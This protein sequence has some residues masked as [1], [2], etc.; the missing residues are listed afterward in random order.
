MEAENNTLLND[1]ILLGFLEVR[2]FC[3]IFI[4]AIY[5]MIIFGNFSV[6]GIIQVDNH[7]QTPMYFFLSCLSLLDVCYSTVTLPAMLVN[8][9]T[10]NRRISFHRCFTQLYFFVCFGGSECLLLAA[11]AYDRYVA[12][13]NPLRYNAVMNRKFCSG[14]VAGCCACG[15]LNAVFHTLMILKLTFCGNHHINH[16]FCDVLPILEAACS[17][18]QGSQVLL[19]VVTVFLGM[20]PFLLVMNSYIHIISTILKIRSSEGRQKVFS[21]CSS[22]LI[23][24]TIFYTTGMFS[25]NGPS[26]G[27]YFIIVRVSS[28]LY[29][30]LP[31]LLNPI[32]YCLR[33]KDVKKALKKARRR[34]CLLPG[35][36][37]DPLTA[38]VPR[39][40]GRRCCG[41]CSERMATGGSDDLSGMNA[42]EKILEPSTPG[43]A[44][45][46]RSPADAARDI[47]HF[48]KCECSGGWYTAALTRP[49]EWKD[50]LE[51]DEEVFRR[52]AKREAKQCWAKEAPKG[53]LPPPKASALP[54]EEPKR[55]Q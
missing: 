29:G 39:V 42:E 32:I 6:F 9:I 28:I 55:R 2:V 26:S 36:D 8:A 49:Y 46:S 35:R 11:M 23:V 33:N 47:M 20:S 1:F 10:G 43:A 13:C 52:R 45:E 3:T 24:V 25:Y 31:P 40:R 30:I 16:F 17:D 41:G 21:T 12:I 38:A 5:I 44:I 50:V 51:K 4:A 48:V 27:D 22:H 53:F 7:L 19:H 14:F 34:F 54:A 18:I 37:A 15:L